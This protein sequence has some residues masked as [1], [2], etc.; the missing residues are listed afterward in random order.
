MPQDLGHEKMK[1]KRGDIHVR[2]GGDLTAVM[3]RDK[4]D[5]YMLTNQ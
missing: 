3:W 4:R 1:L 2:T 5:I